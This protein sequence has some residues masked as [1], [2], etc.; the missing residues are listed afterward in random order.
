M[1]D[2]Y[3][4]LHVDGESF[5]WTDLFPDK[6][7]FDTLEDAEEAV[8]QM[9]REGGWTPEHFIIAKVVMGADIAKGVRDWDADEYPHTE[10]SAAEA[11]AAENPLFNGLNDEVGLP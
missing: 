8:Q 5:E 2:L 9:L 10:K 1:P 11:E 7:F 6:H 4:V 3:I